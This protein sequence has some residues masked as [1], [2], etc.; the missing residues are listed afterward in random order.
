[1]IRVHI[2]D[3]YPCYGTQKFITVCT[4]ASFLSILYCYCKA[5]EFTQVKWLHASGKQLVKRSH[6]RFLHN[7]C[8]GYWLLTTCS[9]VLPEKLKCPKLLKNFPEF[10]GIRRFI[11]AF[12]RA[13]HLSLSWARLIQSMPP[14]NLSKIH[15]N[16]IL[17]STPG[18]FKWSPC[19]RFP[20]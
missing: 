17:P 11:T 3:I 7:M 8:G 19:L 15:F 14:F 10:Y 4:S 1:M 18:S 12:A 13:R 6:Q 16:I 20:H 2:P 9:R 5:S